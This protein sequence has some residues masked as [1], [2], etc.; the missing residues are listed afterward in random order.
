ML[1][2]PR[3]ERTAHLIATLHLIVAGGRVRDGAGSR[4]TADLGRAP[5]VALRDPRRQTNDNGMRL[6]NQDVL[7]S[8][9]SS[10]VVKQSV[11]PPS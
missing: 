8:I 3:A 1:N 5:H 7:A 10:S 4:I 2:A 9:L 6:F 11:P